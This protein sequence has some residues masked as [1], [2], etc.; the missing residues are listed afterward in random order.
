LCNV[1]VG[2]FSHCCF[3][4]PFICFQF[5]S[6][7]FQS[8]VTS[9]MSWINGARTVPFRTGGAT[10]GAIQWDMSPTGVVWAKYAAKPI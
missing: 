3:T 4:A 7:R 10:L 1:V 5:P 8:M 2:Q 6:T 9:F